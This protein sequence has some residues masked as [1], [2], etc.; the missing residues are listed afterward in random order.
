VISLGRCL[1]LQSE[2][3]L[4]SGPTSQTQ[5]S[6]EVTRENHLKTVDKNSMDVVVLKNTGGVHHDR[7]FVWCGPRCPVP[8]ISPHQHW[9]QGGLPRAWPGVRQWP[10]PWCRG[11]L[12]PQAAW[13]CGPPAEHQTADT[14]RH[15]HTASVRVASAPSSSSAVRA[16]V[17]PHDAARCSGVSPYCAM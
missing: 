4:P 17:D 10:V 9:T 7:L 6:T 1:P 15:P 5:S 12:Q 2:Q 13:S 16:L 3:H 8:L 14:D 11:Q